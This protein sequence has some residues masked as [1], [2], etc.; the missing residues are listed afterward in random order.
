MT[1]QRY[2]GVSRPMEAFAALR[3]YRDEL[4]RMKGQCRKAS[5]DYLVLQAL[6]AVLDT[7]AYH[8]TRV[9]DFYASRPPGS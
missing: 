3:P 1:R 7:A 2:I 8:F 6:E 4:V 9:P 5:P